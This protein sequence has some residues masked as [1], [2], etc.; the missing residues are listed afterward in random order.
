MEM[1]SVKKITLRPIC[2]LVC[3]TQENRTPCHLAA[4]YGIH[5][6]LDALLDVARD[7]AAE[8]IDTTANYVSMDYVEKADK[9]RDACSG[10]QERPIHPCPGSL[11]LL[12]GSLRTDTRLSWQYGYTVLHLA[13]IGSERWREFMRTKPM[14][15]FK[16]DATTDKARGR[17]Q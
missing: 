1:R 2:S 15:F 12:R 10:A 13:I 9:V 11:L 6:S 14:E 7:D 16:G 5:W 17:R 3:H 4:F 8:G